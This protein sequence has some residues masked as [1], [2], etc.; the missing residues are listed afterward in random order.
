MNPRELKSTDALLIIDVQNDFCPGGALPVPEGDQIVP[1]INRWIRAAHERGAKIVATRDWHPADHGSFKTR[2]GPWPPH[3]VQ[4]SHGAQFHP[5]LEL[6][7]D[8]PIVSKGADREDAGY[9]AIARTSLADDLKRAA[10]D[11]VFVAGLATDVCVRA[12]ALDAG[13]AGFEVHV[14]QD[15]TRPVD[16]AGGKRALEEMKRHGIQLE[17]TNPADD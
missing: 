9:S 4:G 3:C 5:A 15:A 14:I 7:D 10:V 13:Q 1:V 17:R 2:G 16:A 12:T 8:T 11:R 6:A